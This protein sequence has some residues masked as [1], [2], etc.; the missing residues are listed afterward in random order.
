MSEPRTKLARNMFTIGEYQLEKDEGTKDWSV[1][2]R[3]ATPP[4]PSIDFSTYA[5][6][7]DYAKAMITLGR[8]SDKYGFSAQGSRKGQ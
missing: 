7:R 6:A 3:C 5:D 2:H 8:L 1:F 4:A